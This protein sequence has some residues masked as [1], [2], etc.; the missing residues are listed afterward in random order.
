MSLV[1]PFQHV[2]GV[3][4]GSKQH[5]LATVSAF[6]ALGLGM[7]RVFALVLGPRSE[8]TEENESQEN[9]STQA[10][11]NLSTTYCSA[12][13]DEPPYAAPEAE[14]ARG[15]KRSASDFSY[16]RSWDE[17]STSIPKHGTLRSHDHLYSIGGDEYTRINVD[18]CKEIFVKVGSTCYYHDEDMQRDYWIRATKKGRKNPSWK[19]W[20]RWW[21][22]GQEKGLL[23]ESA[24]YPFGKPGTPSSSGLEFRMEEGCT[25]NAGTSLSSCSTI[26]EKSAYDAC[27]VSDDQQ[28]AVEARDTAC[29]AV[30]AAPDTACEAAVAAR[31]TTCGAAVAAHDQ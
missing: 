13:Q 27:E 24:W 5:F 7:K 16:Q 28:A 1:K 10:Q 22:T 26:N 19:D 18:G 15:K 9:L 12:I 3:Y 6:M 2:C 31:D 20:G 17:P 23:Q 30:V 21:G 29:E 8:Q 25:V 11:E 14:P 4:F